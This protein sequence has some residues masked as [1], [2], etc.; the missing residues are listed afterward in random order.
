M[1]KSSGGVRTSMCGAVHVSECEG[2]G[3]AFRDAW[4]SVLQLGRVETE[5]AVSDR[6]KPQN[7]DPASN[8][9]RLT[10]SAMTWPS[11]PMTRP[12]HS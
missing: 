10:E 4:S 9:A 5:T 7:T 1:P 3:L 8:P 12:S 6:V 11:H 2:S